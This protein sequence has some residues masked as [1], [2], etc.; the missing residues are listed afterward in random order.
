M[1]GYNRR[2]LAVGLMQRPQA[3]FEEVLALP[4]GYV[5]ADEDADL[6][7]AARRV[8]ATKLSLPPAG[9][10][11]EQLYTISGRDRDPRGWS[12]S[13]IYYALV[14]A[15]RLTAARAADLVLA[16]VDA[17]PTLAF[18]HAEI[19]AQAVERLRG[20]TGY[21]NLPGF[22]LPDTFTLPELQDVYEQVL[23]R[24]LDQSVF[25]RRMEEL[26]LIE[27]VPDGFRKGGRHRPAQL[28][29]LSQAT[30]ALHDRPIAQRPRTRFV[31]SSGSAF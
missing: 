16:P 11:L 2:R 14:P 15:A 12:A 23:G 1:G 18:D 27:L 9:L 31:P 7:A 10:F 30:A 24:R 5:H 22:L 19:V 25:R 28:Y 17:L 3:P 13:V 21:S 8:L 4:G 29:R 26:A 20:K 6:D